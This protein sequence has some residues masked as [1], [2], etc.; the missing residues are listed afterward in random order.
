MEASITLKSIAKKFDGKPI[1]AD[2]SF[3]VET[4]TNFVIVGKNGA[5]KSTLLKLLTGLV[6]TDAGSAYIHGL[7]IQSRGKETR[8]VTGYMPQICN[9]DVDMTIYDNIA[10]YAQLQGMKKHE[11]HH[12]LAKFADKLDLKKQLQLKLDLYLL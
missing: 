2:L 5:G 3:G 1:L 12:S 4:G 6:E 8:A 9:L 11:I 7:N 10:V